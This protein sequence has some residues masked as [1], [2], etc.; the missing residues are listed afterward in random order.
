MRSIRWLT[1]IALTFL[2][3]GCTT[4]GDDDFF[5]AEVLDLDLQDDVLTK[6][7]GTV[8]STYFTFDTHG[9]FEEGEHVVLVVKLPPGLSYRDDTAEID[10]DGGDDKVGA[11][12][13]KCANG[14]TYLTFDMDD[15]D[16][17]NLQ[18]PPGDASAKITLTVD[19]NATG[20]RLIEARARRDTVFFSCSQE[21][22]EDQQ[23]YL[24]VIDG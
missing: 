9:V 21:F 13:T 6:G 5:D 4:G 16:L 23:I 3:L 22:L 2:S 11:Q 20:A 15:H 17:D 12:I 19:G 7:D 24:T 18:D 1:L 14:D 8:L 10:N